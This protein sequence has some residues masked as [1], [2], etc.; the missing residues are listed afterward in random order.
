[1]E[2]GKENLLLHLKKARTC[3]WE[4]PPVFFQHC[5]WA[6]KETEFG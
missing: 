2:W 6:D 4:Q 5:N 3:Y 1:M